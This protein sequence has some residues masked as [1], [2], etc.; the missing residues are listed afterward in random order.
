MNSKVEDLLPEFA[1]SVSAQ[2]ANGGALARGLA[3]GI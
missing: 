3:L 1:R 2:L